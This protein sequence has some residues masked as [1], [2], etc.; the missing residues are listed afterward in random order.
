MEASAATSLHEYPA[1]AVAANRIAPGG[2]L[3]RRTSV[4]FNA[5]EIHEGRKV[6]CLSFWRW[7]NGSVGICRAWSP[8]PRP[9]R[10][11]ERRNI[12]TLRIPVPFL[13]CQQLQADRVSP[14]SLSS[15]DG[16]F[17][18]VVAINIRHFLSHTVVLLLSP[19][20]FY[21]T[22]HQDQI[23]VGAPSSETSHP[24]LGA[25]STSPSVLWTSWTRSVVV[26]VADDGCLIMEPATQPDLGIFGPQI[27]LTHDTSM[28]R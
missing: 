13:Y 11:R 6:T 7:R 16:S 10:H 19:V 15:T 18:F 25:S 21:T 20:A 1:V 26:V 28:R 23:G 14:S 24:T 8:A 5:M 9:R 2:R 17:A 22:F 4:C 27:Y 12:L 3:Q